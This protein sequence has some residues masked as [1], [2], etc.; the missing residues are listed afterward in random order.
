MAECHVIRAGDLLHV[1]WARAGNSTHGDAPTTGCPP[2]WRM[3]L[4]PPA[5]RMA[6]TIIDMN[7]V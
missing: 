1:G 3:P 2:R 4:M 6:A 5:E 7:G